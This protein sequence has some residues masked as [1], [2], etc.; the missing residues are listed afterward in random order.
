MGTWPGDPER[1]SQIPSKWGDGFPTKKGVGVRYVDPKNPGNRVRIDKGRPESEFPT[2]QV[3]HVVVVRGGKVIGRDGK[4]I[5]T[6]IRED[7]ERS[8]IP[9]KEWLNW[10]TWDTK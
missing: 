8:H 3:D 4:P 2:Q 10:T 1:P 9:L 6:S 5:Q 7:Y